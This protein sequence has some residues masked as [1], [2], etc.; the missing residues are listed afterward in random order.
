MPGAMQSPSPDGRTL[1]LVR[2]KVPED[3][4]QAFTRR[5][6]VIQEDLAGV[7]SR[8]LFGSV[9]HG[10]IR[11]AQAPS[12]PA[13]DLVLFS[14]PYPNNIDY[15]EVYKLEAWF[16]GL[17]R[18]QQE[19]SLQRR[20]TLR[21]HGSLVW[22]D[23]YTYDSQALTDLLSPLVAAVPADRYSRSRLQVIR[24]YADDMMGV[25]ASCSALVRPGGHVVCV[26]GN[27]LHG[28]GDDAYVVASDLLIAQL[29]GLVGLEVSS[30]AVARR[31]RRRRTTSELMR[32]SVVFLRKAPA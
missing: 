32:E 29:A 1:R 18:N 9:Q 3:P 22:D 20:R 28:R 24:G 10:D 8:P 7:A 5:V 25:L 17:V 23:V 4:H 12:V 16:L 31:P 21:S 30:I 14:P 26:V 6:A 13:V 2:G 11:D 27:S 15:T 19:F